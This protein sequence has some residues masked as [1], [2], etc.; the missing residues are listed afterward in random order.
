[1]PL[2]IISLLA[3]SIP[4]PAP[5]N[6]PD[7]AQKAGQVIA[8][9]KL[10]GLLGGSAAALSGAALLWAGNRGGNHGFSVTGKGLLISGFATLLAIPIIIP[11]INRWFV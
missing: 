10:I 5:A 7:I 11:I 3:V 8:L 2:D 4:N 6:D 9:I 1:M